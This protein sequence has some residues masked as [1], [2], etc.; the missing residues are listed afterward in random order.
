MGLSFVIFIVF[1][2][3]V[4]V[5]KVVNELHFYRDYGDDSTYVAQTLAQNDA[6]WS[7]Y[8]LVV[9]AFCAILPS[10]ASLPSSRRHWDS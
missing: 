10:S 8:A 5:S 2:S 9:G 4:T 1:L 7:G 6:I 3:F